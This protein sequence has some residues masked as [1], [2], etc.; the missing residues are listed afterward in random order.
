MDGFMVKRQS[1]SMTDLDISKAI[2]ALTIL[3][4]LKRDPDYPFV[5]KLAEQW[6]HCQ[7]VVKRLFGGKEEQYHE[8]AEAVEQGDMQEAYVIIA[9]M[10]RA[11]EKR[12]RL[13]EVSLEVMRKEC[14]VAGEP[15]QGTN[16]K[17][18]ER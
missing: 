1:E 18:R 12:G 13:V 16:S 17:I 15:E 2:S 10:A 5:D 9:R 4:G 7:P 6:S 3:I 14:G 8:W 11:E